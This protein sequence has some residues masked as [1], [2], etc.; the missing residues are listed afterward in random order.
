MNVET[1]QRVIKKISWAIT[2]EERFL[3]LVSRAM[4]MPPKE[5]ERILKDALWVDGT[6]P[7]QVQYAIRKREKLVNARDRLTKRYCS[8]DVNHTGS[9][10]HSSKVGIYSNKKINAYKSN[11]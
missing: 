6:I 4:N 8:N 10:F 11:T 2:K 7:G 9:N 3:N 1:A 5:R